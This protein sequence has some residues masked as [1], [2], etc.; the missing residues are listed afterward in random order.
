MGKAVGCRDEVGHVGEDD[1][2]VLR[3]M[4]LAIAP[5]VRGE[6]DPMKG[7]D[8]GIADLIRVCQREGERRLLS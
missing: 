6:G 5:G 3:R 4:V 2:D 8:V 1:G 7:H